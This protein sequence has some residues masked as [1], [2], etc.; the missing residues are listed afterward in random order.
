MVSK[1]NATGTA[2]S[3]YFNSIEYF[4]RTG[5]R[6]IDSTKAKPIEIIKLWDKKTINLN[7]AR[8]I[9]ITTNKNIVL[10]Y[11][12]M[13][14]EK[15][16]S[17]K[18]FDASFA[19]E[20]IEHG[21]MMMP[22]AGL[23]TAEPQQSVDPLH[24]I[25]NF[26]GEKFRGIGMNAPDSFPNAIISSVTNN[27]GLPERYVIISLRPIDKGEIIAIDWKN[28]VNKWGQHEEFNSEID[29][30]IKSMP[31]DIVAR[32]LS[33]NNVIQEA[34]L[35]YFANTPT[36]M[37]QHALTRPKGQNEM[38]ELIESRICAFSP[39]C[40]YNQKTMH[41]FLEVLNLNSFVKKNMKAYLLER[42]EGGRTLP[43][44]RVIEHIGSQEDAALI[45]STKKETR[46]YLKSTW[47]EAVK[48][49]CTELKGFKRTEWCYGEQ[50]VAL[51]HLFPSIL[52]P[53][54]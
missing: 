47:N 21:Q 34:R 25:D 28:H 7:Y 41:R 14:S 51:E 4:Y 49:I 45:K 8:E 17:A 26:D 24:R 16:L 33:E 22:L 30:F 12:L 40:Q 35:A 27:K 9:E 13:P 48:T 46:K 1:E 43:L 44:I 50:E 15:F 20:E 29:Y 2:H 23:W 54:E 38:L 53:V 31:S 42:A 52:T 10:G 36:A 32:T 19:V 39:I 3:E 37:L 6:F 5:A 11:V 18:V